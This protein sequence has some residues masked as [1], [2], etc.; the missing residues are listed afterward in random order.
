MSALV[1]LRGRALDAE[2]Y[3]AGE[4]T[5]LSMVA[6]L[7]PRYVRNSLWYLDHTGIP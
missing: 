4:R 5:L 2:T 6:V 1:I 7:L 3:T